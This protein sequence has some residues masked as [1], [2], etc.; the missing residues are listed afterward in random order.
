MRL[1][2]VLFIDNL[3]S[4]LLEGGSGMGTGRPSKALRRV[5]NIKAGEA[6]VAFLLFSY[7][8]LIA[9]PLAIIKTLRT[10]DFLVRM[11]VGALPI[12]YLLSAIVTGLIILLHSKIQF[13]TSLRA[14]IIASLVFFAVSGLVLQWV[15][16]TDFGR[17][18]A[19]LPYFYWV[20]AS[21]LII[22]LLTHF[23][24][25]VNEMLN[26]R[27]A[28]RFIGF[29]TSG[30]ICGGILGGLLVGFLS[31]TSLSVWLMPLACAMLVGC[32]LVVR[33]VFKFQQGRTAASGGGS[34]R[35]RGPG[36]TNG[37]FRGQLQRRP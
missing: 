30:G 7:F 3:F 1:T 33:A 28:K 23:W 11:G 13:R 10:T 16:Q 6:K 4:S 37:R 15:L 22:A 2:G 21:V 35:E 17:L 20:W 5:L 18:S 9:A 12:A 8:F 36:K 34:G 32:V 27:E 24:M 29:L 25:T 19:L 26:P 31:R 14:V